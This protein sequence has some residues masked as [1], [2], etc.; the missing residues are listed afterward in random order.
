MLIH[1]SNK[2]VL[3]KYLALCLAPRR[4][5]IIISHASTAVSY[6]WR[7][8]GWVP[9][10]IVTGQFFTETNRGQ[11]LSLQRQSLED[12]GSS[13]PQR[14]G[15][16]AGSPALVYYSASLHG[17]QSE[18]EAPLWWRSTPSS[19]WFPG[20]SAGSCI[21]QEKGWHTALLAKGLKDLPGPGGVRQTFCLSF[22]PSLCP[23][24]QAFYSPL[25]LLFTN[26]SLEVTS[27]ENVQGGNLT[28]PWSR[29]PVFSVPIGPWFPSMLG[30]CNALLT[31]EV[32]FWG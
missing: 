19:V 4:Y 11:G 9:G 21:L 32:G 5:A 22:P 31:V 23:S 29:M 26:Y 2:I 16:R 25:S 12:H 10:S 20:V 6:L 3:A 30:L 7:P 18:A 28:R 8:S 14:G 24:I 1:K 27:V 17:L 15:A 13:V